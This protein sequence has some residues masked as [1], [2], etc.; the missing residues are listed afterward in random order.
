[1]TVIE[2][3]VGFEPS[4]SVRVAREKKTTTQGPVNESVTNVNESVDRSRLQGFSF[5]AVV[6]SPVFLSLN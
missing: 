5:S 4:C 1:M 6:F 3:R 2:N